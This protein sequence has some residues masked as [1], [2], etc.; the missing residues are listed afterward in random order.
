MF[1]LTFVPDIVAN[2]ANPAKCGRASD[3]AFA[4]ETL[5]DWNGEFLCQDTLFIGSGTLVLHSLGLYRPHPS[6]GRLERA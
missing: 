2:T 3:I 5:G 1:N 4:M 6:S